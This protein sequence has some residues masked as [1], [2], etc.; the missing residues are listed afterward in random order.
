MDSLN[1]AQLQM[2]CGACTNSLQFVISSLSALLLACH[3]ELYDE[4]VTQVLHAL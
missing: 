2:G 4:L 3:L 1:D